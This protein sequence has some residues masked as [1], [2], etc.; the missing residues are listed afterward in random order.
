MP[1]TN[2]SVILVTHISRRKPVFCIVIM[3]AFMN[4]PAIKTT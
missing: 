4:W 3:A 1:E 2:D